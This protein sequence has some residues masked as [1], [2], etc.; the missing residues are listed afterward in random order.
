LT[1]S[2]LTLSILIL[3]IMIK[4]R[5]SDVLNYLTQYISCYYA[6]CGGAKH[7]L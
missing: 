2:T 1:L 5:K 3:S 4:K 6:E 7:R